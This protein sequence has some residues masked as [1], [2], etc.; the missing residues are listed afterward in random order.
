M[1]EKK[2]R[3]HTSFTFCLPG[4]QKVN[5]GGAYGAG[6]AGARRLADFDHRRE[7]PAN[8]RASSVPPA[9]QDCCVTTF[10][11]DELVQWMVQDAS[12]LR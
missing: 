9:P 8:S 10:L 4:R 11:T 1:R 6:L 7:R 5:A 12:L 2:P 3:I